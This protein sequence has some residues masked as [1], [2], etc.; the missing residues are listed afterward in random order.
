MS[1]SVIERQVRAYAKRHGFKL[2]HV[3]Y[4]SAYPNGYITVTAP[5][6]LT[7]RATS[8]ESAMTEMAGIKA[9]GVGGQLNIIGGGHN[10]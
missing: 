8:F 3:P 6:G 1:K 2:R 9:K 5:N 4:S 10:V 7:V